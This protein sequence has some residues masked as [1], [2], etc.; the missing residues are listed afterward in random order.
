MMLLQLSTCSPEK[1]LSRDGLKSAKN[2]SDMEIGY[3]P[4]WSSGRV[5]PIKDWHLFIED[6]CLPCALRNKSDGNKVKEL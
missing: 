4:C 2:Q 6:L 5:V 3:A 1:V